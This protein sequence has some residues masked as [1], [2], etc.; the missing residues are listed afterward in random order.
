MTVRILCFG[1]VVIDRVYELDALP[2]G[3]GKLT[4]RAYRETGGGVAGTAAVAIAALGATGIYCGAVGDDAAGTWLHAEM[5]RLG[6]DVTA[7]QHRPARTPSSCVLV[8][9]KGER[10]LVVDRGTVAPLAPDAAIFSGIGAVL[11]DHRFPAQAAALLARIPERVPSVLDAEGGEQ[12]GLR[13]LAAKV[14][15]PIFSRNGLFACTGETDPEL[16]LARVGAPSASAVGVTLG[17]QGSLW[18]LGDK[19]LHVPAP[20]VAVK[21]TT[22][23]GDVFHGAFALAVAEKQPLPKAIRFAT[24]AAALKAQHG[25]GW[26]GMARRDQVEALLQENW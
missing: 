7:V 21:D 10:C 24:A 3:E 8:D 20:R 23:C 11:V 5:A 22:G 15:Y 26:H 25:L 4:A 14:N 16:G 13:S 6:V 17:E 19:L 9:A 18:R 1:I 12:A 2:D